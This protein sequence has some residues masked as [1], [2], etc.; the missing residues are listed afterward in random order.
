MVQI[1]ISIV[2]KGH[3][4]YFYYPDHSCKTK[5][6]GIKMLLKTLKEESIP[7]KLEVSYSD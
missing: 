2:R 7:Y 3:T 1:R 6:G 5:D 4:S